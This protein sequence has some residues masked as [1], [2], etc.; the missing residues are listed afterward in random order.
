[1]SE[2]FK[3]KT[4]RWRNGVCCSITHIDGNLGEKTELRS[5]TDWCRQP[6]VMVDAVLCVPVQEAESTRRLYPS[7]L[8]WNEAIRQRIARSSH[9]LLSSSRMNLVSEA[10]VVDVTQR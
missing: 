10:G 5:G 3:K 4:P 9:R 8:V 6:L 1:M 2:P 7:T